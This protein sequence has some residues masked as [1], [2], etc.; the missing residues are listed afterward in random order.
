MS[1]LKTRIS[2]A[3]K[4]M[5]KYQINDEAF[6]NQALARSQ[7]FGRNRAVQMQEGNIEQQAADAANQAR[8]V[9][10]STSSLLS[11]I[12]AINASKTTGLRDLA[13]TE[14][15]IQQQN[16][17]QLYGAN[18]AMID[19]KDKA[20]NQN[21]YAPW[22]AHLQNLKEKKANRD[23]KWGSI[24]GGLLS[25]GAYVLGGPIGGAV[26]GSMLGS[27]ARNTYNPQP[28]LGAEEDMYGTNTRYS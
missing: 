2:R 26:A 24:A 6:E 8:N 28:T 11:T 1:R 18:Q 4:N 3:I 25:A 15:G 17:G 7:A 21:V 20:W 19:E 27:G 5:P 22:A 10:G 13:Q 23:A 16:M 12:S 14:A 9:T